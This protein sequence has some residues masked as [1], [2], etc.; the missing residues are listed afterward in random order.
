MSHVVR[1]SAWLAS[2]VHCN[3]HV[4]TCASSA[5][6]AAWIRRLLLLFRLPRRPKLVSR[7]KELAQIT[8]AGASRH[9]KNM[10]TFMSFQVSVAS[11]WSHWHD[12]KL[13]NNNL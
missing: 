3:A 8:L 13:R 10:E 2:G 6:Q 4:G 5:Y 12:G 7:K 11:D 9:R 1:L